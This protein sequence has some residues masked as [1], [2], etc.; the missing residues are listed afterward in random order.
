MHKIEIDVSD[1]EQLERLL[2]GLL[3]VMMVYVALIITLRLFNPS[4]I[5]SLTSASW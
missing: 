5:I 4:E 3:D 2:E 1:V